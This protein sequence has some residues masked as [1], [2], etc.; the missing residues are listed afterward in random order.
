MWSNEFDKGLSAILWECYSMG[1]S[2]YQMLL[3]KVDTH[4][5]LIKLGQCLTSY[6]RINWVRVAKYRAKRINF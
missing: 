1:M 3:G 4:M 2:F 6:I 5:Q